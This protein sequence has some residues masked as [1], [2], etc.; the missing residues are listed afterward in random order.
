[1]CQVRKTVDWDEFEDD[2][3]GFDDDTIVP[4]K[5]KIPR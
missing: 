4:E 2:D 3:E 5:Y 1:M